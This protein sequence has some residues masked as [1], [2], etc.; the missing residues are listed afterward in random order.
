MISVIIATRDRAPLLAGTLDAL[1]Q[2]DPPGCPYEILIV[3]NASADATP[4]VV[5][6]AALRAR[7][8][9]VY[10][11]EPRAGKSHALNTALAHAHGDLLVLTDDDVL[12]SPGWLAAYVRAFAETG[13]DYACGRILPL[14]QAPPPRWM[15]PDLYG[16]IAVPDGGRHKLTLAPGEND[17]IMPIGANM[18]LRRHVVDRI[19]GW[20]PDLGKLQ[21][22]LRTGEDHEFALKMMAAGFRGVYEPG[23]AVRHLVPKERLRIEYF[24]QWFYD[25]GVIVA[26]LEDEYPTATRYVFDV[27]RH[28]W[29]QFVQDLAAYVRSIATGNVRRSTAARMRL[30]WFA[31]F[32]KGRRMRHGRRFSAQPALPRT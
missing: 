16:V 32:V 2:Q 14:W 1:L 28:L 11:H 4:V 24:R 18:A 22:T 25:N 20:N 17:H 12:P 23:A 15:S 9:V 7:V 6:D 3:D 29:R 19:G 10:L 30:S 27:P 31:G 8:P 21:G 26:G 13:A 5:A